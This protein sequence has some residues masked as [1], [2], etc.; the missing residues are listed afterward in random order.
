MW[1]KKSKSLKSSTRKKLAYTW[2]RI[3]IASNLIKEVQKPEYNG[4]NAFKI[5]KMNYLQPRILY[6]TQLSI[7]CVV[8][9]DISR[10]ALPQKVYLTL[11][12][13]HNDIGS[14]MYSTKT[15]K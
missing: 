3:R 10:Y 12:L 13:Y 1:G 15:R 11:T 8:E 4:S 7:N 9:K 6:L 2:S 14:F 5:L